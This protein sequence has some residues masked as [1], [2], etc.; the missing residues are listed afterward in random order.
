MNDNRMAMIAMVTV[1]IVQEQSGE[2]HMVLPKMSDYTMPGF[3][4]AAAEHRLIPLLQVR[5]S[6]VD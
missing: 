3:S 5:M 4:L 1:L 6:T 2:L